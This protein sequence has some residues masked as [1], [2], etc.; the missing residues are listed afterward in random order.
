MTYFEVAI[1]QQK[2]S[3]YEIGYNQGE[4][5]PASLVEKFEHIMNENIDVLDAENIFQH[6]APHLLDEMRVNRII[7]YFL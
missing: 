1:D 3:S 2:G 6:F 7:K 4:N 5:I